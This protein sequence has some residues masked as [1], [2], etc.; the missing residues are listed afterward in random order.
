MRTK[1]V[2]FGA[3]T[4]TPDCYRTACLQALRGQP[5]ITQG[6]GLEVEA[7]FHHSRVSLHH[8][9]LIIQ[10][11]GEISSRAIIKIFQLGGDQSVT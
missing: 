11:G 1:A 6:K 2:A 7:E 8:A 3:R 4:P 9:S 10:G 5:F